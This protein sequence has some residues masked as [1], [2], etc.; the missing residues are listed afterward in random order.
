LRAYAE[1]LA[2]FTRDTLTIDGN[3]V[4]QFAPWSGGL[5]VDGAWRFP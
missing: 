1:A 3:V 5:G 2:T 4:Y